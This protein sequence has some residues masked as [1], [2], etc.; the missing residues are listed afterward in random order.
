MTGQ[1]GQSKH[2]SVSETRSKGH[3]YIHPHRCE[4]REDFMDPAHM[5][6]GCAGA[7]CSMEGRTD[8]SSTQ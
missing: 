7:D 3:G 8:S 2:T 5:L 4:A 6:W 1:P